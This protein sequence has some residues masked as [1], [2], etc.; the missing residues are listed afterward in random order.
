[1][2]L[3]RGAAGT[4]D[5]VGGRGLA[6][7]GAIGGDT[8]PEWSSLALPG[9]S[10]SRASSRK[11]F[12]GKVFTRGGTLDII[13]CRRVQECLRLRTRN[14]NL[15]TLHMLTGVKFE[16]QPTAHWG[17][18]VILHTPQGS[19]SIGP[20]GNGLHSSCMVHSIPTQLPQAI[21]GQEFPPLND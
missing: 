8:L 1:M 5:R 15:L 6:S 9:C 18:R 12:E 7:E 17:W 16:F 11:C 13:C 2:S 3:I 4:V 14:P 21:S 10:L 20:R 19:A